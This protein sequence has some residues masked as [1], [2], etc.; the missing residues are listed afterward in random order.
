MLAD[1]SDI[2]AS[3]NLFVAQARSTKVDYT[4]LGSGIFGTRTGILDTETGS[5]SGFGVSASTMK[6][7]G[8]DYFHA[9]FD[10]V[11][12]F[13]NYTGAPLFGNAPFGSVVAVNSA[14]LMDLSARFGQG[15]ALQQQF[16]L[17]P[18]AE[19]GRH[20]WDRGV[21]YGETYTHYY[22]GLGALAQYSPASQWVLTLNAM[23]ARTF[24]SYIAVNS[25][26]GIT[27]FSGAL[28]NSALSRVGVA[29]DY[30]F[31]HQVHG[32]AGMDYTS[33]KYG[34][35]SLYP[36]VINGLNYLVWEPSSTTHYT[37]FK[38]GL[39]VAF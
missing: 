20:Q 22:L 6:G 3:N 17:T 8:N 12:G 31:N 30:A 10:Y 1:T 34:M 25:G 26:P 28:G 15:Y 29:I 16:M 21:N 5:V 24:A 14:T 32:T 33:F 2:V 7:A 9:E 23:L 35:S 11:N 18:Y 27:G 13:T 38:V 19:L 39:G 36:V 4:E 37:T